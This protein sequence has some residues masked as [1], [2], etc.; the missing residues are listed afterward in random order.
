MS[1]DYLGTCTPDNVSLLSGMYP[2]QTYCTRFFTRLPLCRNKG[3]F[4][5][6]V[7]VNSAFT[8]RKRSLGQGIIFID[9]CQ[10]FCSRG[11]V[12]L[13][14]CW[15]TPPPP[16]PEQTPA[17]CSRGGLP[18]CMLGYPHP[19]QTTPR[20]DTPL[21]GADTPTQNRHTPL[22]ADTTPQR[23]ACWEIRSTRGRY[24]SYW[25]GILSLKTIEFYDL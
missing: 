24:A 19:E 21:P 9:V 18:K 23:R 3:P 14:A 25:N 20:A 2:H 17:P 22:G 13:S 10:E 5:P 16:P 7:S 6:S 15:D 4:T 8:A 12:C 11:G 1:I